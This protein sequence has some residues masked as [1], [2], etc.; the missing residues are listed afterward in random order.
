MSW[1]TAPSIR[2][3][4]TRAGTLRGTSNSGTIQNVGT[5]DSSTGP[6][7]RPTTNTWNGSPQRELTTNP[8][9][10]MAGADHRYEVSRLRQQLDQAADI[11]DAAGERDEPAL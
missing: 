11:V 6:R 8:L 9:S 3:G 2:P 4:S 1:S 7:N 5:P 10:G